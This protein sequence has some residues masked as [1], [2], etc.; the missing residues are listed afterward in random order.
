MRLRL[1]L[2]LRLM[3]R[4]RRGVWGAVVWGIRGDGGSGRPEVPRPATFRHAFAV[5]FAMLLLCFWYA[6]ALLLPCFCSAFA[7]PLLC[8]C[9]ASALRLLCPFASYASSA[10]DATSSADD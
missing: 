10:E 1:R 7:V 4:L 3:V 5:L 8:F 2:R 9:H 6:F